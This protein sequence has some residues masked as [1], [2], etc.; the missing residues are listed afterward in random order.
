MPHTL[1]LTDTQLQ[2][3]WTRVIWT[4]AVHVAPEWRSRFL[5]SVAGELLPLDQIA[6]ADV[7][8]A[9][10]RVAAHLPRCAR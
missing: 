7:K 6:D 4:R 5:E 2:V 3:I 1:A 9:A 8:I 10:E